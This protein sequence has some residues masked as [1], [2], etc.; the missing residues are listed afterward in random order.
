MEG[1]EIEGRLKELKA[2]LLEL[3]DLVI[4]ELLEFHKSL[5]NRKRNRIIS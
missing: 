1:S 4:Q 5:F 2:F 3:Q